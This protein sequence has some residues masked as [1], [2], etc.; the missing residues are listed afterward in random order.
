MPKKPA[1]AGPPFL[2]DPVLVYQG[3][4]DFLS[5]RMLLDNYSFRKST[6]PLIVLKLFSVS[7]HL[8]S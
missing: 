8:R 6:N 3:S 5:F 4:R 2:P 7:I 1:V